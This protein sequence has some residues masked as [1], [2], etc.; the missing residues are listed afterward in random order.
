MKTKFVATLLLF[1][2]LVSVV[3]AEPAARPDVKPMLD[4]ALADMTCRATLD[5]DTMNAIIVRF[6]AL[7]TSL[8]PRIDALKLD[9]PKLG[10]YASAGN[11]KDYNIYV[12][13]TFTQH[14]KLNQAAIKAGLDSLKSNSTGM[15][16]NETKAAL[17]S[18]KSALQLLKEANDRCFDTKAHANMVLT[19]YNNTLV[20]YQRRAQ[21]LSDRGVDA[22]N[23]LA[24]V[25]GARAQI[26]V[27]LKDEIDR[28]D[29]ASELR[30][31][32]HRY[33]LYDGCMNGTNFHMAARFE[34]M[35][36]TDL[37][38]ELS[39]NSTAAD[40]A[41]VSSVQASIDA[42]NAQINAWGTK[43]VLQDQLVAVWIDIRSAAKGLSDL[44]S[45]LKGRA[46]TE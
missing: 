10:Q 42:A 46:G 27:P 13:E 4:S 32:L 26:F 44:F 25:E 18:L 43:D 7:A 30:N 39:K 23:L 1:S 38:A 31:A 37:L 20:V 3:A 14:L 22:G 17:R 36:V 16:K 15:S 29:N 12:Q 24:L 6:P 11:A 40:G 19:Y 41:D 34:T 35:R 8:N 5:T 9:I 33:C 45:A 21:N 2:F 28:T